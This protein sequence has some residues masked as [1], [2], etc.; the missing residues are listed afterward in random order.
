MK[1]DELVK[2]NKKFTKEEILAFVSNEEMFTMEML[3]TS[4]DGLSS[5]SVDHHHEVY[6]YNVMSQKKK[7]PIIY[8][9]FAQFT[10]FMAV[11]LIVAGFA[12][13]FTHSTEITYASWTVVVVNALFSFMQEARADK[14]M[15]T[16]LA[17]VP[18]KVKVIR[19]GIISEIDGRDLTIGDVIHLDAGD[20]VPADI[21]IVRVSEV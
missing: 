8:K 2:T 17:M 20:S 10:H 9:L 6:G 15:D 18:N 16:L 13:Y 7:K 19:D 14:A 3:N 11:L 21:R 4:L 1:E 5:E 12:A